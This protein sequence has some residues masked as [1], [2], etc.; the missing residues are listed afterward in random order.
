MNNQTASQ[1]IE[2]EFYQRKSRNPNYS[3]RSFAKNLGISPGILSQIL[4]GKKEVTPK[5]LKIIAPKL[6]LD[7]NIYSTLLEKQEK[8]KK[9]NSVKAIE[10]NDMRLVDME[11]FAIISD[12]YHF[13]IL[14]LFNLDYFE[15]NTEWIAKKLSITELEAQNAINSLIKIKLLE[16]NNGKIEPGNNFTAIVDYPYTS[17]AMRERQKQLLLLSAQK[18]ETLNISVRDHSAITVCVDVA[19]MP[20]IKDK[21]KAFR[22]SLGNFIAKNSKESNA[23]Y[24]MQISFFPV[25]SLDDLNK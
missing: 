13:A 11:T 23:V 10:K 22:R 19:L 6:N 3:L 15:T 16:V 2:S 18:L 7:E 12:W 17:L 4:N 8:L 25:S 5:V 24:E 20:E 9:E 1:I 14:E 21:I